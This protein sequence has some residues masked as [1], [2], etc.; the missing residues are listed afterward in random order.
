MRAVWYDRQGRA[1]E[2]LQVGEVPDPEPG[3][4]EVRVRV[5]RS[6]VNPGDTKKRRGWLGSSMAFPRVIPHS[7]GAG[8][9]DSAGPGVDP[10][11]VG[12]RV[13]LYGAQSY[14]PFGTAAQFTVVPDSQAIELP[15]SVSDDLGA[16]LGI[17]GITAHRA[18]FGDGP[19]SDKTI[20]VQGVLGAVGALAA[21]LA[22]WTGATVIGT[23]RSRNDLAGYGGGAGQVVALDE[24]DPA[25]AIR[26]HAPAGV[27]R[28]IEVAFSRQRRYRRRRR[29]EQNGD[30]HL[31]DPEGA[32]RDPV[33]ADVVQ[34]HHHPAV[35]QRRLLRSGEAASSEGPH[36]RGPRRCT[37]GSDRLADPVGPDGPGA[38]PCRCRSRKA[39]NPRNPVRRAVPEKRSRRSSAHPAV[40]AGRADHRR[41]D[42][43]V[44]HR[45]GA[46][47][48]RDRQDVAVQAGLERLRDAVPGPA[49][50]QAAF[51]VTGCVVRARRAGGGSLGCAGLVS[52]AWSV[53]GR[54]CGVMLAPPPSRREGPLHLG[55]FVSCGRA[56]HSPPAW[57]LPG[58]LAG[59]RLG[60]CGRSPRCGRM[61]PAAARSWRS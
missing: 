60:C 18:V 28:I 37:V 51:G 22:R 40:P 14:R 54:R 3:P 1:S 56:V 27:D 38:Q 6:G 52:A 16:C 29:Q 41:P 26:S 31:H 44:R 36:S 34:Q 50:S 11:R 30:R 5:S 12:Q 7:D 61:R 48:G 33:L 58:C 53:A 43:R 4:G 2:V 25:A 19:V 55:V 47:P 32:T 15:G 10:K 42:R 57:W 49:G 21:Q 13:W 9:I 17:P 35:G 8:V 20:L 24:P 39:S 45:R 23:V 46:R 59:P